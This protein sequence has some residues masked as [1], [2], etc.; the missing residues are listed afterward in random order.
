ML[1]SFNR[2]Q[3]GEGRAVS[4]GRAGVEGTYRPGRSPEF[5]FWCAIAVGATILGVAHGVQD[6][7]TMVTVS[8]LL[9]LTSLLNLWR[10]RMTGEAVVSPEGLRVRRPTGWRELSWDEVRSVES[11]NPFYPRSPYLLVR[12]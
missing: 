4:D 12:T 2:Q 9:L 7:G 8:V 1:D 11:S 10:V 3:I 6:N 5:F